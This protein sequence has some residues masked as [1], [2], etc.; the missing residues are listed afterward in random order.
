[1]RREERDD[2]DC[3][4]PANVAYTQNGVTSLCR[5]NNIINTIAS[6]NA[7]RLRQNNNN[8][9]IYMCGATVT[10]SLLM[11]CAACL[12]LYGLWTKVTVYRLRWQ[13][14]GRIKFTQLAI[15]YCSNN[16][17]SAAAAVLC[18]CHSSLN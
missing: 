8:N 18:L 6:H 10:Y 12:R 17:T 13:R 11:C 2:K 1:M 15:V 9:I 5:T 4:K 14:I 7:I 16:N 3:I